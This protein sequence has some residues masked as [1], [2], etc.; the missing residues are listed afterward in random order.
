MHFAS[1]DQKTLGA[2]PTPQ[3]SRNTLLA[4]FAPSPT[5]SPTHLNRFQ[6]RTTPS[7]TCCTPTQVI[8]DLSTTVVIQDFHRYYSSDINSFSPTYFATADGSLITPA[9]TDDLWN[10]NLDLLFTAALAML[11]L[12][13]VAVVIDYLRRGRNRNKTILYLL[14]ISQALAPASFVPS[15]LCFFNQYINCTLVV[16]ISS[17]VGAVALAILL[18]GIIGIKTY[19]CMNDSKI[20]GGFITLLAL[21]HLAFVILDAITMRGTRRIAGS[22]LRTTDLHYMRIAVALLMG[23]CCLMML[24]FVYTAI[25]YRKTPGAR[26]RIS[27]RMSMEDLLLDTPDDADRGITLDGPQLRMD[28]KAST[29]ERAINHVPPRSSTL[30]ISSEL[31]VVHPDDGRSHARKSMASSFSR[32]SRLLSNMANLK[33]VMRDELLYTCVITIIITLALVFTFTGVNVKNGLSVTSWISLTWGLVSIFVIHS[34]GRV[35]RRQERD[36]L[37]RYAAARASRAVWS[38]PKS[39][40]TNDFWVSTRTSNRRDTFLSK[41]TELSNPFSETR[42]DRR[43]SYQSGITSSSGSGLPSPL[44]PEIAIENLSESVALPPSAQDSRFHTPTPVAVQG[45]DVDTIQSFPS[46]WHTGRSAET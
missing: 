46:N 31:P 14:F 35:V 30:R 44:S 11:F 38:M 13:N 2:R 19:R 28:E 5:Y 3:A 18:S 8:I 22:C 25:K 16:T 29:P 39:A 17:T 21:A 32:L 12:R 4:A 27:L 9:L 7:P 36:S 45:E 20:I 43:P 1:N 15:L 10:A 33:K 41:D 23:E 37:M 24:C 34:S 6:P 40:R 42:Q 26:G